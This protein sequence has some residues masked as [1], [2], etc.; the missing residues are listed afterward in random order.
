MQVTYKIKLKTVMFLIPIFSCLLPSTLFAESD[1]RLNVESDTKSRSV[2]ITIPKPP[3]VVTPVTIKTDGVDNA[4]HDRAIKFSKRMPPNYIS[5]KER[6]GKGGKGATLSSSTKMVGEADKG[7][8]SAYLRAPIVGVETAR[9]RLT[10]AGFEIVKTAHL[11]KSRSLVSIVFTND[12]LKKLASKKDRGFAGTLRL[13]YDRK[14]KQVSITNPIYLTKAM[15]QDEYNQEEAKKLLAAIVKAF[16]EAKGSMDKLKFQLLPKYQFMNGMPYYNDMAVVARGDNLL[17]KLENNKRVLYKMDL[18]NGVTLVGVKLGKR[19]RKFTKKIGVKN[20][21][22]L[23]YPLVIEKG[24][25][26]ILD[27]K[28]YL[29]LMYPQLTMEEFMTIATIPEAIVKDCTRVFR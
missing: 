22:M 15:L 27:P 5:S 6:Y 23:P 17:A 11:T 4:Q 12:A 10:A 20:A 28:Y 2:N 19:T 16:P 8:V 13:L 18:A 3:K 14:N 9:K 26:K 29:S 25:A 7:R 1:K 21:A 24:E